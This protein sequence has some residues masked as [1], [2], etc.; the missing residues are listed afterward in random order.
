MKFNSEAELQRAMEQLRSDPNVLYVEQSHTA[1]AQFVPNDPLYSQQWDKAIQRLSV[2][3]D[4]ETGKSNVIV[5]VSD[6]AFD[7]TVHP[8][9]APIAGKT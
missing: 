1:T 9:L 7:C 6:T 2:A 8:D 3:N 5:L 4:K